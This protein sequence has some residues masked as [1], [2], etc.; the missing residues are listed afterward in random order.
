ME[1]PAILLPD[2][3]ACNVDSLLNQQFLPVLSQQRLS[4]MAAQQK[5]QTLAPGWSEKEGAGLEF[6]ND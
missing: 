3:G 2:T 1:N 6:T 5:S 4:R